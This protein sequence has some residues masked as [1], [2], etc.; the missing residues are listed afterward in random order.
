M[1]ASI[2]RTVVPLII[3]WVLALPVAAWL[4]LTEEQA[5]SA[6]T[7]VVTAVYYV[8]V[9]LAEQHLSP[10]FGWLLG[11]AK[12]PTYDTPEGGD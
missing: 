2:V 12:P 7:A 6:A 5:T 9:R 11:L 4:G 10:R 3:G 8:A 1:L